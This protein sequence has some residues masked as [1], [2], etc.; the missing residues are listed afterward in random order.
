MKQFGLG[1]VLGWVVFAC[2]SA[3]AH[4]AVESS[5]ASQNGSEPSRV[6]LSAS[7]S[8][9]TSSFSNAVQGSTGTSGNQMELMLLASVQ[10]GSLF[11]LEGG[12]GWLHNS[13]SGTAKP[14]GGFTPS[15]YS[16]V[17]DAAVAE[18]SPQIQVVDHLRVGFLGEALFGTDVSFV[19]GF[20]PGQSLT[21]L[22]GGQAL[23]EFKFSGSAVRVG[24]RY[25]QSLNIAQHAL[26]SVQATVQ[27]GVSVL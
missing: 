20:G 23:Y 15:S 14:S 16:L 18:F 10:T 5:A 21:W 25:L 6:Y 27:F 12:G 13:L 8:E 7:L 26:Q 1:V 2:L 9:G 3:H 24:A 17:T 22:A 4:A 19:P 11:V